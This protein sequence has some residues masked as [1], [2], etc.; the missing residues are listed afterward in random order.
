MM[1]IRS[2]KLPLS[3]FSSYYGMNLSDITGDTA[4]SLT[5]GDY[6]K[7]AGE[8]AWREQSARSS[9]YKK[10]WLTIL[11]PTSVGITLIAIAVCFRKSIHAAFKKISKRSWRGMHSSSSDRSRVIV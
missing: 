2:G 4:N 9:Y 6:W 7:I 8:R 1:L 10:L 5:V 3:F 11:G